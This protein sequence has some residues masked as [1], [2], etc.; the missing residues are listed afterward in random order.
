M[1]ELSL[2][3]K[4]IVHYLETSG[5]MESFTRSRERSFDKKVSDQ[6]W[7]LQHDPVFTIGLSKGEGDFLIQDFEIEVIKTNRGGKVTYHGPGQM[8]MYLLWDIESLGCSVRQFVRKVEASIVL[9]LK[10]YGISSEGNED[11][12]GVY[13]YGKKIASLG[14][15]ISKGFS[16]HG[17]SLNVDMDLTPFSYINPCGIKSAQITQMKDCTNEPLDLNRI[18]HRLF[19]ILADEFKY[20]AIYLEN[21]RKV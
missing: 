15:R 19:Q 4:G 14:F 11:F 18:G 3:H 17:I 6:C 12:P 1:R 8:V 7:L 20:D 9:L 13:V 5:L 16:F 21:L 10:E 2:V